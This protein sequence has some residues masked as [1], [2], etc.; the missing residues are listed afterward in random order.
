MQNF[1]RTLILVRQNDS[2]LRKFSPKSKI[3]IS[4]K[5]I[6]NDI[7]ERNTFLTAEKV[8]A[9]SEEGKMSCAKASLLGR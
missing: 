3:P 1:Y 9:E 6:L 5:F 8:T 4:L 7:Q 2:C